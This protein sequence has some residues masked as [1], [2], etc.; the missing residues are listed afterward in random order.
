MTT[1]SPIVTATQDWDENRWREALR[2]KK[3]FPPKLRTTLEHL[4]KCFMAFHRAGAEY[5]FEAAITG[6]PDPSRLRI[7]AR[8]LAQARHEAL[9]ALGQDPKSPEVL[10]FAPI[11]PYD[12]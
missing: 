6:A 2:N 9:V 10:P 11:V 7:T 4:H 12:A 3:P 5:H 1:P 8:R